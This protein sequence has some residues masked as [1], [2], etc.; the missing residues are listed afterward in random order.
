MT[1]VKILQKDCD[2]S[3]GDD[4]SLPNTCYVVEY[5]SDG[6]KHYDLVVSSKQVDIFDH[7]YDE[8]KDGFITMY[9]SAGTAN[10]KL[11]GSTPNDKKKK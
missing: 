5:Y 8:Y 1:K 10:P 9:Q 6:T 3:L 11:W 2:R 4:K 7:Y